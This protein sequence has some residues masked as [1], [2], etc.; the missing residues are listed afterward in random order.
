M[1]YEVWRPDR[2]V[3]PACEHDMAETRWSRVWEG[4]LP[5][6]FRVPPGMS[7]REA[8][9]AQ[10]AMTWSTNAPAK[11][12]HGMSSGDIVV[13]TSGAPGEERGRE[14]WLSTFPGWRRVFLTPDGRVLSKV[15]GSEN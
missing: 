5:R 15:Y 7:A 14:V 10:L 11:G 9:L 6:V 2:D 8:V 3:F 13:F 1:R 12:L 4:E